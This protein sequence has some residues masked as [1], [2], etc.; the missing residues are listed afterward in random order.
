MTGKLLP[1]KVISQNADN[2]LLEGGLNFTNYSIM[3]YRID[4]ILPY[5]LTSRLP[6]KYTVGWLDG[7]VDWQVDNY[8]KNGQS[9]TVDWAVDDW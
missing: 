4:N 2:R 7:N 6:K 8:L 3:D 9:S 1:D 5:T